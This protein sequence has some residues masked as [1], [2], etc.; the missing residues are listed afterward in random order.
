MKIKEVK[1]FPVNP[2]TNYVKI[3]TDD[4][5]VGWGEPIVEG[6]AKTTAVAVEEAAEQLIGLDPRN[7]EDVFNVLYRGNF[8]KGGPVLMSAISGIEQALWDIKGKYYNA[9]VYELMGGAAKAKQ[10]VYAWVHG[11]T[12]EEMGGNAKKRLEQGYRFIKVCITEEMEWICAGAKIRAA[13]DMLG[14]IRDAVG[15]QLDI[16]VDFHGR[17]HKTVARQLMKEI[18]QYDILFVEEPVLPWNEDDLIDLRRTTSIPIATGERLYT[19]WDFK[20]IFKAGVV[21]IIQPDLSHAGGLWEV[22]KISA[23][24][25]TYDIAVA[26]HCPLGVIAFSACLHH[27]IAT[28]NAFIQEQ[29]IGVHNAVNGGDIAVEDTIQLADKTY[30][31]AKTYM[32]NT[33]GLFYFE[34]G[35]VHKPTL[36]GLGIDVDEEALKEDLHNKDIGVWSAPLWRMDDG[37]V[38][39]W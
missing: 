23:M 31:P 3:T 38:A 33:A 30:R 11:S 26:P 10:K 37:T 20:R 17:V 13:G 14:G 22:R 18:E 6:R 4:G 27:D 9:P 35:F 39:E 1:V 15:N 25:E 34:D 28:P 12:P 5:F 32:K 19:R 36:P 8:Y 29:V 24:A 7:I 16:G 21:D 2:R